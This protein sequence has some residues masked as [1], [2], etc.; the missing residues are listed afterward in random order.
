MKKYIHEPFIITRN[1]STHSIR[2][3]ESIIK[4]QTRKRDKENRKFKISTRTSNIYTLLQRMILRHINFSQR[5]VSYNETYKCSWINISWQIAYALHNSLQYSFILSKTKASNDAPTKWRKFICC[6]MRDTNFFRVNFHSSFGCGWILLNLQWKPGYSFCLTRRAPHFLCSSYSYRPLPDSWKLGFVA[7]K[8]F[9]RARRWAHLPQN[10]LQKQFCIFSVVSFEGMEKAPATDDPKL[11]EWHKSPKRS[12]PPL[13]DPQKLPKHIAV[14]MDGNGRWGLHHFN[15]RT[16]GH[17]AGVDALEELIDCCVHWQIPLLTVFAFSCENWKRPS[18]E[19][20]FLFLLFSEMVSHKLQRLLEE[21]IRIRFVG[22][23]EDLPPSLQ[24]DIIEVEELS[25]ANS[26]LELTIALNYS[27]RQDI[28]NIARRILR[29]AEQGLLHS[30]QVD[31]KLFQQYMQR[32][33]NYYLSMLFR[34][35]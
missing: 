16:R 4:R 8:L 19:V 34:P 33:W 15:C 11:T 12:L 2:G 32:K 28:V 3:S 29:D 22:N 26:S 31:E 6:L 21:N 10:E 13:L 17:R 1:S 23:M 25:R 9:S 27:G 7:V 30:S 5:G 24:Q 20:D 35:T 18:E 14:I